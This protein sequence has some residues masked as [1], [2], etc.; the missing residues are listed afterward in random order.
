[1]IARTDPSAEPTPYLRSTM[2]DVHGSRSIEQLWFI[3]GPDG[4]QSMQWLPLPLFDGGEPD[5][6]ESLQVR[7]IFHALTKDTERPE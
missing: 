1:M 2:S 3:V 5:D 6:P 4:T 7:A